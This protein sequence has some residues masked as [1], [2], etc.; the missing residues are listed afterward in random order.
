MKHESFFNHSPA[1]AKEH[2]SK[3]PAGRGGLQPSL[4]GLGR[5]VMGWR[6]TIHPTTA[7]LQPLSIVRA[8][9]AGVPEPQDPCPEDGAVGQGDRGLDA[10]SGSI[11][12][13]HMASAPGRGAG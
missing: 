8:G 3:V 6:T 9:G 10:Q 13:W 11:G 5:A 2:G 7:P 12:A 1:W 4:D